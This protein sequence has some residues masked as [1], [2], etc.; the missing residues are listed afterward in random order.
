MSTGPKTEP[1]DDL[2]KTWNPWLTIWTYCVAPTSPFVSG[3]AQLQTTPGNAIPSKLR[4]GPGMFGFAG[5][6]WTT[7]SRELCC[8]ATGR[9]F[10]L[11]SASWCGRLGAACIKR[12]G[13]VRSFLYE[14]PTVIREPVTVLVTC[15]RETG[16]ADVAWSV[17]GV[18]RP[19]TPPTPTS[20]PTISAPSTIVV[21]RCPTLKRAEARRDFISFCKGSLLINELP[22]PTNDR[23]SVGARE[24][25]SDGGYFLPRPTTRFTRAPFASRRPGL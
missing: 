7:V 2:S 12:S 13:G 18:L 23:S 6:R 25:G 24:Q 22:S 19:R 10:G 4:P 11:V 9:G 1:P 17:P 14:C 8:F 3:G 16:A 21:R 15:A 20:R 5:M